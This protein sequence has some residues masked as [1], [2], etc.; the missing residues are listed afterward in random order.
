MC[1]MCGCRDKAW[2]APLGSLWHACC[3]ACG[4]VFEFDPV[5]EEYDE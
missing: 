1:P 4:W 2:A 5:E 3:R